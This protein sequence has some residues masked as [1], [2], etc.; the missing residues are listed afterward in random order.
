MQFFFIKNI[1]DCAQDVNLI[2]NMEIYTHNIPDVALFH[3]KQDVHEIHQKHSKQKGNK[4][5]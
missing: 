2:Q 4:L 5:P 3:R 1:K